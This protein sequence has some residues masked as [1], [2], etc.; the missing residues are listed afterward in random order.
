MFYLLQVYGGCN[1]F[2]ARAHV[3][4]RLKKLRGPFVHP[5][6]LWGHGQGLDQFRRELPMAVISLAILFMFMII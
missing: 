2:C 4:P 1:F 6:E 5:G 3:E